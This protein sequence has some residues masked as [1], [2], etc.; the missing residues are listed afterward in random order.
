[1]PGLVEVFVEGARRL[2]GCAR[3]D[4][5]RLAGFSE[6]LEHALVRIERFVGNERLG[7][8]LWEQG[9]GSGQIMLLTPGEMK[10][11]RI[12]ERIDGGV[13]F[14]AQPSARAS[15]GLILTPFLRAP[16]LCW[17]ARTMVES[18][19]AYSL[20][21]SSDRC[22]KTFSQTPLFAHRLN[23]V[24]RFCQGSRHRLWPTRAPLGIGP[25]SHRGADEDAVLEMW[26]GS[27]DRAA[28]AHRPGLSPVPLP[29]LWQAVQ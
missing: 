11:G 22:L 14:R 25:A 4:H 6:R 13:D 12:A 23:R 2:A 1:M 19:I 3:W 18:I 21:A 20:S 7:F 26:V 10:A 8:K 15:D 17:W 5:R 16:A 27:S 29:R 24:W 28:G 9:I